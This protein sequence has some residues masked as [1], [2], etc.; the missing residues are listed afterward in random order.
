MNV[1]MIVLRNG[2]DEVDFYIVSENTFT[3][4]KTTFER[5]GHS[6]EALFEFMEWFFDFIWSNNGDNYIERVFTQTFCFED[7]DWSMYNIKG[8][9]TFPE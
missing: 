9:L 2:S 3:R 5:A 8:I 7:V 4:V 6:E 1:G